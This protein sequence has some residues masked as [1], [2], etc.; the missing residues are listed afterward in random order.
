MRKLLG[1]WTNGDLNRG[2]PLEEMFYQFMRNGGETGYTSVK[3]IEGHKKTVSD[4]LKKQ[5]SAGHRAWSAL[6]MQLELLNRSAENCA[7]FA[8]FITSREFGRSI[9]RSI[10]DAKE[11]S[12]NFNK[13]GS[14]GKMVNAVGQSWQGK[15]GSYLGGAG[16]IAYVFWNAG[17][18]AFTNFGRAGHRHPAKATA[19]AAAL[20]ALGYV[21]PILAQMLGGGDGDDDDKNAYYNLPEYVR[22]SNICFKA[23]EQ[24][25]TIPLPIEY[26]SIYGLGE[27]TYGVLSGNERYS[28]SELAYHIASQV[29]QILPL[30]MLEGGG[31]VNALIPS[32][33]K[34]FTEAYIMNKGWNGLP[35]Y[36]E[37]PFNKDDPEWTKAYASADQHLVAFSRWLN[38]T[39]G[40]DDFKKGAIDINPAKIEYL[41]NG[42][43]GGLFT[44]PN[45]MKKAGETVF[46][47]REFEWRN[48]PIVN[49]I[50]KSGDERTSK[51]KLQNEYFNYKEEYERTGKLLRKYEDAAEEGMLGYAKK[52]DLLYNS[53]EYLRYEIFDEFKPEIDAY[54]ESIAEESD[55]G[56]REKL[57]E[58]MWHKTRELVDALHNPDEYIKEMERAG[59]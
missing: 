19:G 15:L 41:L 44:F 23:G 49:R 39:S 11:V 25:I 9:D 12:V 18:Q 57:E 38:E 2:N 52:V 16:R 51:R 35:V 54:R 46:S 34:P 8:A 1:K 56:E 29:S 50:I 10:Y 36:K 59:R 20:F 17:I 58:E 21:I 32:A 13:K 4:E 27:L 37:T 30:D 53:Q 31:G 6:G 40:G 3:D 7:R 14:G 45:K 47:D 42:T 55:N 5:G 33:V 48:M 26:R 28:D 22:R 24:W 43:F